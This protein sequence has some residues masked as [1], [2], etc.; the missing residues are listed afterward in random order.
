MLAG[1]AIAVRPG[2]RD[3][4]KVHQPSAGLSVPR[5]I[6][7]YYCC[8]VHVGGGGGSRGEGGRDYLDC[9]SLGP[10]HT[11]TNA[12][13]SPVES[14]PDLLD[15]PIAPSLE[16]YQGPIRANSAGGCPNQGCSTP[17]LRSQ[18]V[19]KQQNQKTKSKP[20]MNVNKG[21]KTDPY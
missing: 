11:H 13:S 16:G 18:A 7:F 15:P 19:F 8:V 12:P 4:Q 6:M 17:F 21:I 20:P 1:A 9:L 10:V 5:E 14:S 3:C 2:K